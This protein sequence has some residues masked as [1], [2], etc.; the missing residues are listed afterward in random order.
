MAIKIGV[1][2]GFRGTDM[3]NYCEIADNAEVVAICDKNEEVLNAQKTRLKDNNITYYDNFEDF[4]NHDMDAV[5]LANYANEHVP[6]A[7]KALKRGLH[8]FSEVL[9]CQTMKEAVELVETVE[10]TGLVYAYG[11]NY[12]YMPAPYEMKKLYKQGKIGEFEYGEGEYIHNCESIWPS[13]TYGERD[14][15][16]NDMY[17][18]FY[19]THSLGPIIHMTG[20]R[21]VSVIGFEGINN[22]RNLRVG[23]KSGQ[24]G[25][26]M[27]TLEN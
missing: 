13:I 11:E 3:I 15:W 6:F 5:V 20:L 27:V 22:E 9:P 25:I 21:P 19:C 12:C 14:H 2:G 1:M 8:V 24:Y 4:I 16:R 10:E 7:I 23:S 17:A 18:T 26:E